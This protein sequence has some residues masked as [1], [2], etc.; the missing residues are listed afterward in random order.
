MNDAITTDWKAC[1]CDECVAMCER[2]PC[3]PTPD[4]ARKL[5][6][7]GYAHRLMRD[8]WVGDYEQG[9]TDII[10]PAI[11][12]REGRGAPWWPT[13]R[14]TMLTDDGRCALHDTGAKPLEGRMAICGDVDEPRDWH[15]DIAKMWDSD[16]GR[17]VVALWNNVIA[18]YVTIDD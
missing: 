17:A 7:L 16:D 6:H 4:E 3:W 8:Y 9:D 12:G 10:A 11:E 13:G 15:G 18:G 14:C 1:D 2:R 5:I